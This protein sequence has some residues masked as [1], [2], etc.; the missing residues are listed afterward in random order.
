MVN[1]I[2]RS[3]FNRGEA[4][5]F[6]FEGPTNVEPKPPNRLFNK[7][8]ITNVL[9]E[10]ALMGTPP[11]SIRDEEIKRVSKLMLAKKSPK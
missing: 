4:V 11:E 6:R 5:S 7:D 8:I 9:Q 1:S 3:K 10:K 2:M